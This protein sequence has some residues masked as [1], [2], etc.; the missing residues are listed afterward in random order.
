[1]CQSPHA[2]PRFGISANEHTRSSGRARSTSRACRVYVSRT[3]QQPHLG[4]RE[5]ISL[6]PRRVR[7]GWNARSRSK[8]ACESDLQETFLFA[9]MWWAMRESNHATSYSYLQ[10]RSATE[11]TAQLVSQSEVYCKLIVRYFSLHHT[12]LTATSLGYGPRAQVATPKKHVHLRSLGASTFRLR[13]DLSM[14]IPML[15]SLLPGWSRP[16]S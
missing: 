13:T 12:C 3:V 8:A 9:C 15:T 1:M 6:A 2:R 11:L 4:G 10:T 16:P 7:F 5:S 14:V